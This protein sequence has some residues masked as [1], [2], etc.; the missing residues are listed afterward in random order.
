M[1]SATPSGRWLQSSPTV[2]ELWASASTRAA[3]CSGSTRPA[4]E[5]GAGK[6]TPHSLA[7]ISA[8]DGEPS[9]CSAPL[10]ASAGSVAGDALPAPCRTSRP[11]PAGGDRPAVFPT[12]HFPGSF[13]PR[14]PA[15]ASS[16]R[17][18]DRQGG[19][20]EAREARPSRSAPAWPAGRLTAAKRGKDGVLRG[21]YASPKAAMS[22]PEGRWRSS[23][24]Q[25]GQLEAGAVCWRASSRLGVKRPLL[26][27]P[28]HRRLGPSRKASS[29]LAD[30]RAVA[31]FDATP[32]NP[33]RE[34]G[35][36]HAGDFIAQGCDGLIEVGGG[37]PIDLAKGV[38][39]MLTE[40]L[41]RSRSIAGTAKIG[42]C[43]RSSPSRLHGRH[44]K[45]SLDRRHHHH[46]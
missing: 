9:S 37:S 17:G 10:A 18:D 27:R 3:R 16:G 7:F 42:P 26:H 22:G 11:Q 15:R 13:Y 1:I 20:Q 39:L 41:E 24:H 2:P 6:R 40:P 36:P 4:L 44:G 25:Q 32:A 45:R 12:A 35:A 31:V 33:D 19:H 38:A 8:E 21:A 30:Q 43:R 28:R 46:R 14:Q 23:I 34:R 5:P 29:P